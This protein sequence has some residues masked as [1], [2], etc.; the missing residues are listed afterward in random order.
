MNKP[1]TKHS[2]VAR[3]LFKAI[4]DSYN[5]EELKKLCFL[6]SIHY[7]DLEGQNLSAKI[8]NL[9]LYSYRHEQLSELLQAL[10]NERPQKFQ[11]VSEEGFIDHLRHWVSS[12]GEDIYYQNSNPTISKTDSKISISNS[13]F[14]SNQGV[15]IGGE[16]TIRNINLTV[17]YIGTLLGN[18]VNN[19]LAKLDNLRSEIS[20][21]Q[22]D[23]SRVTYSEDIHN[24]LLQILD[25]EGAN[26]N[27]KYVSE[28]SNW[29]GPIIEKYKIHQHRHEYPFGLFCAEMLLT[30]KKFPSIELAFNTESIVDNRGRIPLHSLTKVFPVP[31]LRDIPLIRGESYLYSLDPRD[32]LNDKFCVVTPIGSSGSTE[33]ILN[34]EAK[35]IIYHPNTYTRGHIPTILLNVE[36]FSAFILGLVSDFVMISKQA[37]DDDRDF[38]IKMKQL[39]DTLSGINNNH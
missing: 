39:F 22:Q 12:I 26:G 24:I 19:V 20:K 10:S 17:E 23:K 34:F 11:F 8:V 28:I 7:E 6:L 30:L 4:H 2:L 31:S 3:N 25:A 38:S 37:E 33:W 14:Q 18:D 9:I 29:V 15:F 16:N 32:T 21:K 35:K 5:K 1:Q 13:S 27:L 36:N